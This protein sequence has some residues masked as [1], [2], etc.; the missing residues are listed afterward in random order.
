MDDAGSE[1]DAPATGRR[2][3]SWLTGRVA[4]LLTA[5]VAIGALAGWRVVERPG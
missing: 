1:I 3:P 4:V 5:V 2:R